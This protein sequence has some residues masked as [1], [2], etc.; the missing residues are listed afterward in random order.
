[1]MR[2]IQFAAVFVLLASSAM[3]QE[4]PSTGDWRFWCRDKDAGSS[5]ARQAGVIRVEHKGRNDWSLAPDVQI[6]VKPGDLL[7][8]TADLKVQGQGDASVCFVT[9]DAA[10]KPV[11]WTAGFRSVRQAADWT[12]NRARLVVPP[13]IVKVHPRLIGN[14]VSVTEARNVKLANKGNIRSNAALPNELT[15]ENSELLVRFDPASLAFSVQNKR[16]QGLYQQHVPNPALI[17]TSATSADGKIM[18]KLLDVEE[19][20]PVTL[21]MVLEQG[22][23]EL[24]V[25]LQSQG[26]MSSALHYPAPFRSTTGQSLVIPMNEGISFPVE[27]PSLFTW[28]LIAYG[29]HGICMPFFGVTDGK[30]GCMAI[31]Q[32]PDDAMIQI[33]RTNGLGWIGPVWEGQ[34]GQFG[35]TR[36]I[37][38]VFLSDGGHVAMAKR[39]RQYAIEKGLLKT[40]AEKRKERPQI[41]KLI[42]AANIWYWDKDPVK[43]CR[44]MLDAGIDRILWSNRAKPDVLKQLNTFGVLTSRYDIYQDLMDPAQFPKLR[45]THPDWTTEGWPKDIILDRSGKWI[46]GWQIEVKGTQEMIPCGV[47]CDLKAPAYAVKRIG[48]EL[49]THPYGCRFIDTTTASPWRECYSPDHPMTRTQSREAKMKLL[50]VIS[51]QFKL[52]CGSE[53]GHDAAVPY[54]DYF[55]GMLSLGPYRVDDAGRNMMRIYTE[56]PEKLAKFQVG[57]K[58][59]LP[60]WELVYHDA[61]VAQ[62][63]WGDY[64]NKLPAIWWKRDLFN[65][66]YGTPPMYM[67]SRQ[68]WQENKAQFIK[69]YQSCAPIAR[70]T[71][72]SEMT[73]H[74]FL[75]PDRSVQQTVFANGVEVTVNFGESE[76]RGDKGLVVPARSVHTQGMR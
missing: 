40:F 10:N 12:P 22:K 31:L 74:R 75:T 50:G 53:T 41:D 35:Y 19:D 33:G 29:G 32:T 15:C 16:T 59:R 63:Y 46:P 24:L 72:Y 6:P 71:G 36:Q 2:S 38:Y 8:L 65:A 62:W 55:E 76:Y 39:Y 5:V 14:G 56:V 42:G 64:N 37:R 54:C 66:L 20:R 51:D 73:D 45:Y 68:F 44:E 60:L 23:P 26:A 67:F 28:N 48:E 52:V 30:S 17:A 3:A 34:K 7:E 11:S 21:E 1:M 57:E 43:M 25:S 47:L 49:K 58:Y 61:C 9:Y 69:S 18:A 4:L 13:N 27:D 70:A